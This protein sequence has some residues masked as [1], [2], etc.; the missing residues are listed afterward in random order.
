MLKNPKNCKPKTEMEIISVFHPF[1]SSKA[2][3]E[4]NSS[5]LENLHL[6]LEKFE[7]ISSKGCNFLPLK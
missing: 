5:E 3:V 7:K 4:K 2:L 1:C 6:E